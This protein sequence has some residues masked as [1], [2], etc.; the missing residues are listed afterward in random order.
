MGR[1]A[2]FLHRKYREKLF[3]RLFLRGFL[4]FSS[5]LLFFL[6]INFDLHSFRSTRNHSSFGHFR[7]FVVFCLFFND[8]QRN[9]FEGIAQTAA[10]LLHRTLRRHP[11]LLQPRP[12]T[13]TM[14]RVQTTGQLHLF[15]RFE[16]NLPLTSSGKLHTPLPR[17]SQTLRSC[18]ISLSV[19]RTQMCGENWAQCIL[20]QRVGTACVCTLCRAGAVRRRWKPGW[21]ERYE[22][23]PPT[24]PNIN[25]QFVELHVVVSAE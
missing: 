24:V 13:V 6:I 17:F 14:K 15:P 2:G 5:N 16:A 20:F 4:L 19:R 8:L 25:L 10:F 22:K 7:L 3:F 9:A 12:Q 1:F 18:T 23:N 21:V 11:A